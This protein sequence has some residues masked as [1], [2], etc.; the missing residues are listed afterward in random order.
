MKLIRLLALLLPLA[1]TGIAGPAAQASDPQPGYVSGQIK[2]IT[3]TP[4]GLLIR[5]DDDRVP[6]LCGSGPV[7]W[8]LVPQAN[9]TMI[10]VFLTYWAAGKKRFT[11]YADP[12]AGGYCTIGQVDPEDY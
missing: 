8:M 9:A 3:S 1:V 10:S 12:V 7:G 5:T 4:Q 6:T 2:D 11:I